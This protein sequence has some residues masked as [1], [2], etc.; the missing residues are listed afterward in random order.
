MTLVL[1]A[2]WA[3]AFNLALTTAA[4]WDPSMVQ[5]CPRA[6]NHRWLWQSGKCEPDSNKHTLLLIN[7][8]TDGLS[9]VVRGEKTLETNKI[10]LDLV[11]TF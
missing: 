9:S 4:C 8:Q 2:V 11:V 10:Q 1:S 3:T 5:A 6:T 7:S